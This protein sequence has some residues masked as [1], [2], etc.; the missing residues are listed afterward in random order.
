M[1]KIYHVKFSDC[2]LYESFEQNI[3]Y[4]ST[5]EKANEAAKKYADKLFGIYEVV[6]ESDGCKRFKKGEWMQSL[7]LSMN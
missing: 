4:F 1:P 5:I 6:T 2:M 3:G 7:L